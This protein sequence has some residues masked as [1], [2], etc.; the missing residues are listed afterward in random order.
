MYVNLL[1]YVMQMAGAWHEPLEPNP[2]AS[3]NM[4]AGW[5]A[6]FLTHSPKPPP[7]HNVF[8]DLFYM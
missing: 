6:L 2:E 5:T 4:A 3:F 1:E 8:N 7:Y